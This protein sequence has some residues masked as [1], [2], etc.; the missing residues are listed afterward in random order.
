MQTNSQLL[1]FGMCYFQVTLIPKNTGMIIQSPMSQENM[2]N[3]AGPR[4]R[5]CYNCHSDSHIRSQCDAVDRGSRDPLVQIDANFQD[6]SAGNGK[7]RMNN[8]T[9]AQIP[10]ST[11]Q[12]LPSTNRKKLTMGTTSVRS[13]LSSTSP[14]E[15]I[16]RRAM[17]AIDGTGPST[18]GSQMLP[19]FSTNFLLPPFHF[20]QQSKNVTYLNLTIL[21]IIPRIIQ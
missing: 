6:G 10:L 20:S 5:R 16:L 21:L 3:S 13:S 15:N 14:A 18:S 4:K 19:L 8:P 2:A 11:Y 12:Q 1:D 9:P 17:N 7:L